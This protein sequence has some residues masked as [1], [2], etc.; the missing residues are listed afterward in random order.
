MNK[1]KSISPEHYHLYSN[2]EQVIEANQ[3]LLEFKALCEKYKVELDDGDE[4]FLKF[5]PQQYGFNYRELYCIK[6]G[7]WV[8]SKPWPG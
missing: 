5:R 2:T 1:V 6:D 8:F 4:L 3:F 7:V